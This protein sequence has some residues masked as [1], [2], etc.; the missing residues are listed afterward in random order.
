MCTL[1]L[2]I[3]KYYDEGD[4]DDDQ[5][6]SDGRCPSFFRPECDTG[7]KHA[8]PEQDQSRAQGIE[9]PSES[10]KSLLQGLSGLES[11]D[12]RDRPQSVQEEDSEEDGDEVE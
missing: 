11:L 1:R 5:R 7:S 6:K 9:L 4:S 2:P 10:G 12:A 8:G 3:A